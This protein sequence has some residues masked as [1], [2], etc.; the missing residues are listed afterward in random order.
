MEYKKIWNENLDI[1]QFKDYLKEPKT[2]NFVD[3]SPIFNNIFFRDF[4]ENIIKKCNT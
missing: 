4:I 3:L 2:N 1:S